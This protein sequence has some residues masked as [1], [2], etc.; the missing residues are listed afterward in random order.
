MSIEPILFG[1]VVG[2]TGKQRKI[3]AINKKLRDSS[4]K[5]EVIIKDVTSHYKNK[6]TTGEISQSVKKGLS[7]SIYITGDDV[8]KIKKREKNWRTIDGILSHLN[9]Y[10]DIKSFSVNQVIDKIF[11]NKR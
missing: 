9:E 7:A 10:Y 6:E 5:D 4:L 1:R 2:I 8:S 3:D 11:G